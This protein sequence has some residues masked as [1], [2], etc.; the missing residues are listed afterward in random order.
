LIDQLACGDRRLSLDRVAVMGVLN[1]T[2]DSF[3]DG[4]DL[5]GD[6][7]VVDADALLRRADLMV[8]EGAAILD[9]GAESTRPGAAPVPVAI[10]RERIVLALELLKPRFDVVLS[11][12]SSAPEV[13]E[14]A[15]AAGAGMLNDVRALRRPGA[16]EAA[17]ATGL[18]VCLMHMQ[19][20]PGTMQDRPAYE[21]VVG[22][23]SAFLRAR[24]AAA[25][26][27][28]IG[29]ERLLVDP[30]FGFGKTL[31]HNCELLRELPAL[32]SLGVPMLVGLSRKR[33]IGALTGREVGARV[34][35]SIAAAALAVRAG[36][37]LVRTHDV[38]ETVDAVRVAE[39]VRG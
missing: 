32:R 39:A 4:G 23:V 26:D 36:A 19:G 6:G 16:L 25:Q 22:E 12:D 37:R 29:E 38:A 30:G 20:E 33:M 9:L 14:A 34:A 10:E 24:M 8:T 11:V 13:Y 15:V 28:G 7:G 31:D 18:P 21:D 1:L 3:S 27:A 17:A 5:L 35:G 2:P